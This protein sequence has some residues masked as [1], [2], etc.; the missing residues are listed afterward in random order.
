MHVVC[1]AVNSPKLFVSLPS[2]HPGHSYP[3]VSYPSG[4][5]TSDPRWTTFAR[6][7]AVSSLHRPRHEGVHC[8]DSTRRMVRSGGS[9][10]SL[11]AT[12]GETRDDDV[13]E[14]NNAVDDGGEDAANAVDNGHQHGADGL[15]E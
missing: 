6:V 5:N 2:S 7:C 9:R 8:L 14:R 11:A 4:V 3:S 13:E 12:A 15:A 1:E 10:S